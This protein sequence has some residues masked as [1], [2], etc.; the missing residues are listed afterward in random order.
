MKFYRYVYRYKNYLENIRLSYTDANR[1]GKVEKSEIIEENNYYS[2][3]LKHKGYNTVLRSTGNDLAQK[4][5]YNGKELNEELGLNWYDYG[6]RNYQADLGRWFNVDP[7]AEK[8]SSLSPYNY[9]LN[10]PLRFIDPDGNDGWDVVKGIFAAVSDNVALGVTKN[11]EKISYNDASDYNLG[12]DI[13]DAISILLGAGEV[14]G[15]GTIAGGGAVATVGSGG[16]LL[17]VGVPAIVGGVAVASHGVAMTGT[18]VRNLMSQKGRVAEEGIPESQLG[19]SGKPKI[20]TVKKPTLKRTKDAARN[21]PKSNTKPVKHASDKGQKTH[22]HP[23]RNGKKMKGKDNIHYE[24]SSS[25][26]N[27]N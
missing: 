13:G 20:H 15:G 22:Y 6:A 5:K 21:N 3:G 24:D 1:D 19:P 23:T 9:A 26:R 8:Y 16:I 7:L 10:N 11:R 12:Q 2:F 25:K 4:Y 27:L 17:E 18:G 14:A